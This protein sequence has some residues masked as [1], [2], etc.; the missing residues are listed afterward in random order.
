MDS[1]WLTVKD[2]AARLGVHPQFIYEACGALGLTH[3]RVGRGRGKIRIR[4][5]WLEKWSEARIHIGTQVG[6]N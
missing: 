3:T 1:P 5:V 6:R 2:A 4:Q